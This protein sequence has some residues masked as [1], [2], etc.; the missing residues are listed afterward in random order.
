MLLLGNIDHVRQVAGRSFQFWAVSAGHAGD[1]RDVA[2]V[3]VVRNVSRGGYPQETCRWMSELGSKAFGSARLV[4]GVFVLYVPTRNVSEGPHASLTPRATN[5]D[6]ISYERTPFP[7]RL[8][9]F[10]VLQLRECRHE[11]PRFRFR[12]GCVLP[13]VNVVLASDCVLRRGMFRWRLL[14][15]TGGWR[16]PRFRAT[17]RSV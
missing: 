14:L 12:Y 17:G 16:R 7:M 2:P 1:G 10:G 6:A 8:R 4:T 11:G 9:P 5:T 15:C 3:T 13:A